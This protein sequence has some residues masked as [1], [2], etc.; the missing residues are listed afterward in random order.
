LKKNEY[1]ERARECA[2][3]AG[4][5]RDGDERDQLLQRSREWMALAAQKHKRR[6]SAKRA[7]VSVNVPN[8]E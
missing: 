4:L 8:A 5:T 3:R 2:R 7:R 1:V 6:G